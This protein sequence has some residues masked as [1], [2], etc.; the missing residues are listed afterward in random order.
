MSRR[1]MR[2][3]PRLFQGRKLF[4]RVKVGYHSGCEAEACVIRR[5]SVTFG[6]D[7]KGKYIDPMDTLMGVLTRAFTAELDAD[8]PT[9]L[10]DSSGDKMTTDEDISA[11]LLAPRPLRVASFVLLFASDAVMCLLEI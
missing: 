2:Q 4:L 9:Q 1:N 5:L 11:V 10:S 6:V 8:S 3:N 7:A